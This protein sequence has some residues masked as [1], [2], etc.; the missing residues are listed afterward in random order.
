MYPVTQ[1]FGDHPNGRCFATAN[2]KGVKPP[3]TLTGMGWL[4]KQTDATQQK[5][6]GVGHFDSWKSGK[7]QLEDLASVSHDDTW[8]EQVR[9]T[10]LKSLIGG[11]R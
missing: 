4:L 10:P 5:I 1:Q 9:I 3:K 11:D 7:L 6:M 8:G 2:V